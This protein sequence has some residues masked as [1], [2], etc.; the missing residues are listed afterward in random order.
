MPESY[1][2]IY[3]GQLATPATPVYTVPAGTNTIIKSIRAVNSSTSATSI[4]L[5][6]GGT[7][8]ANL[9]LP[10]TSIEAGGWAE[11]NGTITLAAADTLAAQAGAMASITLTVH[12]VEVS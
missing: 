7:S 10:T 5:W 2:R 12:G 4:T 1:K 11:F 8:N 6:Q 3:Q 9:I